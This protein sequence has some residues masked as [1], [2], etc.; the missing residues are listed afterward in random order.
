MGPAPTLAT[1]QAAALAQDQPLEQAEQ[2]TADAAHQANLNT[3]TEQQSEINPEY[4][5]ALTAL[6]TQLTGETGTLNQKYT[7][8]LQGNFSGLQGN[9]LGMLYSK[10]NQDVTSIQTQ[11]TNALNEVATKITNEDLTYQAGNTALVSKYQGQEAADANSMYSAALKE[12]DTDAYQQQELALKQE[13]IDVSA[14]NSGN[15]AA[16][17]AE[18][19]YKV[20][21]GTQGQ[22]M[23]TDKNGTPIS[24][25]E[26]ISG[27][28]L[29]SGQVLDLLQNGT[30]Y[31]KN[32][33]SQVK[34]LT[35]DA[36][37]SALSKYK[38]YGF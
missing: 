6:Q 9:D 24:M 13:S 5:Q 37:Q 8:A 31:D 1:Y 28:G 16:T 23:Y 7:E 33:Y 32:V 35:G 19:G 14:G 18:S 12:Y 11:R 21:Q 25:A 34:G 22:Y 17:A 2:T 20:K 27:A 4:D 3:L 26:Y 38:V 29:G 15:S 30:S 10:A 36:L